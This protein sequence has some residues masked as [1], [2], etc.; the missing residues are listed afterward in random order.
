[1]PGGTWRAAGERHTSPAAAAAAANGTSPRPPQ[2]PRVEF[3]RPDDRS[4]AAR[5]WGW[6]EVAV[7]V[8]NPEA[9]GAGARAAQRLAVAEL[10]AHL[11]MAPVGG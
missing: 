10:A 11:D 2:E 3:W 1:M 8:V 6:A 5:G 9:R 4:P 7:R